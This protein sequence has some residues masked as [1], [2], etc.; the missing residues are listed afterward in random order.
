MT[1][2]EECKAICT[3][4]KGSIWVGRSNEEEYSMQEAHIIRL[5][6]R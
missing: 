3:T 1:K 2:I 6:C 5:D 4:Q